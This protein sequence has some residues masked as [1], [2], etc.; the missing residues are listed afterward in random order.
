[1]RA[2]YTDAFDQPLQIRRPSVRRSHWDHHEWRCRPLVAA[3]RCG[4]DIVTTR[5]IAVEDWQV[6]DPALGDDHFGRRTI[7]L[8]SHWI[9][10]TR[11]PIMV[12][13]VPNAAP[14]CPW[15]AMSALIDTE[16]LDYPWFL[17]L[18]LRRGDL[19][20]PAGA[21]LARVVPV[22]MAAAQATVPILPPPPDLVRAER[23]W[24]RKRAEAMAGDGPREHY[25]Y[26]RASQLEATPAPVPL[27]RVHVFPARVAPALCRSLIGLWWQT[28][29]G[30]DEG[31]RWP[32]QARWPARD[33]AD[34]REACGI[35]LDCVRLA[36]GEDALISDPNLVRWIEGDAMPAH[37]DIAG[38]QFPEREW[39]VLIMLQ[40]A[41]A[42]GEHDIA[43]AGLALGQG[44]VLVHPGGTLDHA[45]REVT[46][47]QRYTFLC[48]ARPR[49]AP[50]APRR[51]RVISRGGVNA[52]E[53]QS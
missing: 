27:E 12:M 14:D 13:P 49:P 3:N 9:W 38:G 34:F 53:H 41:E 51:S 4:W 40:P 48:W 8:V 24:S 50:E 19:E 15:A 42:G 26:A 33:R 17:T 29:R 37:R 2:I 30:D 1:M 6:V 7:T 22:D 46:K 43:G 11:G 39:S 31:T 47:G 44:D 32:R 25:T 28:P 5:A 52:V 16:V 35:A 36:I 10:K 23:A 18:E 45:V 20:I 21:A